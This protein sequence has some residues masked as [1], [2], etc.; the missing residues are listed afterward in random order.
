MVGIHISAEVSIPFREDLY[1][2]S[3][4]IRISSKKW[5]KSF[6]PFQ[7]RPLFGQEDVD[8]VVK[9]LKIEFPSLSGKTSIRT[10]NWPTVF[11]I[12]PKLVS[13]PFREDLYSDR[14]K[15]EQGALM[16]VPVVSIPFREDLYSDK[17]ISSNRPS[18]GCDGFHPFQGRP[19]FGLILFDQDE[20][21]GQF[22]FPSLSGKTSIRT[23]DILH[24][25]WSNGL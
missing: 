5:R 7:G 24:C 15:V 10:D 12:F 14:L 23:P 18:S 19:L 22:M 20:L 3:N 4:W 1:S 2:D 11:L 13:I 21:A 9:T 16:E 25:I 6:H 8:E 17:H